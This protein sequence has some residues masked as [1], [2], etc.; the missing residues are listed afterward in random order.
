MIVRFKTFITEGIRQGL[1]HITT[2]DHKQF[3]DLIRGGHIDMSSATEKTD[4]STIKIGHDEHGFY[5]QS[6]GSGSDRMRSHGDYVARATKRSQ[7]TGKPLDLTAAN[8]FGHAHNLM[9]SNPKLQSYLKGKAKEHGETAIKGEL[10]YKPLSRPSDEHPGEV[11]FVGTSYATHHMGHVGKIVVHSKLPENAHHDLKQLKQAGDEHINFD[12][13]VIKMPS[14]KINVKPHLD[15]YKKLDHSLLNARTTPSNKA[16]KLAEIGKLQS[17]Q[18]DVSNKVDAHVSK[19]GL[20]PKWGKGTP[21]GLVVHPP[22][23]STQ[24]R[25]KVTSAAF[26]QFKASKIDFKAR[27]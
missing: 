3:G 7:E 13:D 26:R 12:D 21:E 9:Q 16:Q 1:P 6:S 5:T 23:E 19:I 15:Q 11:K 14:S 24:P 10:F 22:G 27:K 18:N 20:K 4:G 2:M 8:A 25:F 17:I